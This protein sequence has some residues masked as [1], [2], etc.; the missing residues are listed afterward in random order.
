MLSCWI[1]NKVY[2]GGRS[3]IDD[4]VQVFALFVVARVDLL[5]SFYKVSI[6]GP[7]KWIYEFFEYVTIIV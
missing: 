1:P 6:L 4:M 7:H 3:V 2:L 5:W